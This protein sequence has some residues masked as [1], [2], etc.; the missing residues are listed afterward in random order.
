LGTL[1]GLM[2][3]T[4]RGIY[5]LAARG[6]GPKPKVFV[7]VDKTTN[8][9]NNSGTLGLVLCA[10]WLFFFYGANL[11]DGLF[12]AF[13]FDSSELP[14]VALYVFYIPIFLLFM[15]KER[16]LS[17][18][19]RLILPG[20]GV[21]CCVFMLFAAIYSHGQA[22]L[23]FLLVFAVAMIIGAALGIFK[24]DAQGDVAEG[25][26]LIEEIDLDRPEGTITVE[27]TME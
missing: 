6:Q 11:T 1:N 7:Q 10:L 12:G 4:T 9:P 15:I 18:F 2:M 21:F 22:T 13:A 19:K 25:L 27:G 8:M 5:A 24:K 26:T 23:W 3:G 17:R 14:I 20:L 16:E